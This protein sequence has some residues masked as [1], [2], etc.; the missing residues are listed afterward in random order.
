LKSDAYIKEYFYN[1]HIT[2]KHKKY[3]NENENEKKKLNFN[4]LAA[5]RDWNLIVFLSSAAVTSIQDELN[6]SRDCSNTV[7]DLQE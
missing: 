5:L 6:Q 4:I 1:V 7:T 2:K 3:I